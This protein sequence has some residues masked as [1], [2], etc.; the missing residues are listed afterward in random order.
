MLLKAKLMVPNCTIRTMTVSAM[1]SD[2]MS[3][4]VSLLSV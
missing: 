4:I 2:T 1:L 3:A